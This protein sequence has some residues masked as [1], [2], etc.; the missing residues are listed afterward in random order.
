MRTALPLVWRYFRRRGAGDP[1]YLEHMD[2]RRGEGAPF[3]ADVWVHAV[4]LGEMKS[5]EPLVRLLLEAGY[6]VVTTHA[7]PAGRGI[8]ESAFAADIAK[9]QLAVR[10][11]PV[12][13][14]AFWRRFFEGV[15][16]KV[17]LVME[18]E[19]WPA[20]M[21]AARDAGVVLALTNSQV[22]EKSF[23]R[24]ARVSQVMGGHPVARAA[25]VFAKSGRMAGRFHA[26][27]AEDVRVVGETRFDMPPPPGQVSA[28]AA[29]RAALD[30][31]PVVT[32]AS[33]VA[34]E[35]DT[36][37]AALRE[38][39]GQEASPFFVWVPRAP[40]LFDA[41]FDRLQKAGFRVA[42]RSDVIGSDL[43]VSGDLA[44]I[45]VLLGDSMGEMFFFL[46]PADAVVVGGGFVEKGAH[47]VI[48]PLALGKPVVTGP[49]VW[50]IEYPGVEAREA[51]VLTVCEAPDRLAEVLENV[52]VAGGARA[53]AFH[54]EN[55][56]A[57]ERIFEA[58]RP[59]LEGGEA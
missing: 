58:I 31:R 48:E 39:L 55:R 45:D 38:M 32:L 29:L 44:G 34:G 3:D 6:R 11:V 13:L 15:Q 35:E 16:P 5:A 37:I 10:Y 47:N 43:S 20:M 24:A 21:E 18:M 51:G 26:L 19:F 46:A 49:H 53:L 36:Y 25:V 52:I 27:G 41:T 17:G 8:A 1:R 50:T 56:G 33:V 22:P 14:P 4:S 54:A 2:E 23:P 42:R 12:D 59:V 28:G 57:S 40:E 30:G 7:T 9:G